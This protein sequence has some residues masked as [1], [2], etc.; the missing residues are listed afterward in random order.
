MKEEAAAISAQ[1]QLPIYFRSLARAAEAA[2]RESR[3]RRI[4]AVAVAILFDTIDHIWT[5]S[6]PFDPFDPLSSECSIAMS[7]N[8]EAS[9]S[10]AQL[11]SQPKA[12]VTRPT[13]SSA[14]KTGSKGNPSS[15]SSPSSS[16]WDAKMRERQRMTVMKQ[17]EREMKAA[18]EAEEQRKR[19][20]I[21]E[22]RVKKEERERI[23]KMAEKV[24]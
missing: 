21:K 2:T 18:R 4:L 9:S 12:P 19:D 17:K 20:T 15:S 1:L 11:A 5:Q 7:S 16:S 3:R 23:E 22:R 8:V 13:S 24:R 14:S 10:A 6:F